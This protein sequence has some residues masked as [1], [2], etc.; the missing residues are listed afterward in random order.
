MLSPDVYDMVVM[1]IETTGL[2]KDEDEIVAVG[3][4]EV[5]RWR[6]VIIVRRPGEPEEWFLS[7]VWPHLLDK[8]L[9]GYNIGFD[10]GFL[11]ERNP[12]IDYQRT[13]DLLDYVKFAFGRSYRLRTIVKMIFNYDDDDENGDKMP[14]LWERGDVEKIRKHLMADIKRTWLLANFFLPLMMREGVEKI[15][16]TGQGEKD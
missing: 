16:S 8:I 14:E 12:K 4:S 15:A 3:L 11:A 1:D 13:I 6:P 7:R 5:L 10:V 2:D 9:V